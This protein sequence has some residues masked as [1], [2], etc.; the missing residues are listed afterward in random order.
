MPPP[1]LVR[2][3][4]RKAARCRRVQGDQAAAGGAKDS[5]YC[6]ERDCREAAWM[7]PG[8]SGLERRAA[9]AAWTP[10]PRSSTRPAEAGALTSSAEVAS[11]RPASCRPDRRSSW[12]LR[13]GGILPPH[14]TVARGAVGCLLRRLRRLGGAM[15]AASCGLTPRANTT[16]SARRPAGLRS[17]AGTHTSGARRSPSL[18][19]GPST[20]NPEPCTRYLR[21][22]PDPS[23]TYLYVVSSSTPQGPRAWSLS[24][25]MPI[26]AP[27]PNSK[28]SVKRL[29]AFT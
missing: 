15:T 7:P 6:S 28:P 26:S 25:E 1:R 23:M 13:P 2:R 18:N 19:P 8:L 3:A 16:C 24:V 17:N 9:A 11:P 12:A 14:A 4:R 22:C 21:T 29:D 20:L 10:L 27:M 5:P